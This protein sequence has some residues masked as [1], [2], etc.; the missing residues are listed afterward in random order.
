M[1]RFFWKSSSPSK[2]QLNSQ[3]CVVVGIPYCKQRKHRYGK[4]YVEP[5]QH[6][7]QRYYPICK[8]NEVTTQ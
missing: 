8:D 2:Y 1:N 5:R 6:V 3:T 7:K 4:S